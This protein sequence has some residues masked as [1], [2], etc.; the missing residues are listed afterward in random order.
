MELTHCTPLPASQF[1]R[2]TVV[3]WWKRIPSTV[4][5]PDD[6]Y[7]KDVLDH[8]GFQQDLP[9]NAGP[10]CIACRHSRPSCIACRHSRPQPSGR[11]LTWSGLLNG[12]KCILGNQVTV[13]IVAS[14]PHYDKDWQG[15]AALKPVLSLHPPSPSA[16]QPDD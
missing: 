8:C 1:S 7:R 14:P 5:V 13:D 9:R 3:G 16:P 6:L 12:S 11:L 2:F 4:T 15:W 10:S